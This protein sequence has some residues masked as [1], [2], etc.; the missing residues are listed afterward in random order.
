M[1]ETG[2]GN[3]RAPGTT[4]G[5]WK[6]APAHHA[7]AGFPVFFLAPEGGFGYEVAR[8]NGNWFKACREVIEAAGGH[9]NQYLGDG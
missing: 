3:A 5:E 6:L 2:G 4:R 7:A 8:I 1:A 9:M